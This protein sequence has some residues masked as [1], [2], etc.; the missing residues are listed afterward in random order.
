MYNYLGFENHELKA[1]L[2]FLEKTNKKCEYLAF[3]AYSEQVLVR[4][5]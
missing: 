2:E 5:I 4:I 3:N 1:F